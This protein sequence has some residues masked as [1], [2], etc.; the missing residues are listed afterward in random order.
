MNVAFAGTTEDAEEQPFLDTVEGP[1]DLRPDMETEMQWI[2]RRKCL[3]SYHCLV[4]PSQ[5]GTGSAHG[6]SFPDECELP[7]ADYTGTSDICQNLHWWQ[8]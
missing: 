8:C 5:R 1:E 6:Y 7:Y 2:W 4:T 3:K